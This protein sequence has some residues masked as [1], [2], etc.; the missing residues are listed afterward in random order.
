MDLLL[1]FCG[2]RLLIQVDGRS[3]QP[4]LEPGERVLVKPLRQGECPLAG[5]VVLAWHPERNDLRIIKRLHSSEA[6]AYWVLG[7]NPD[8]ST[9]SRQFGPI[10]SSRLIG[11]V[12]GRLATNA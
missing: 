1:L 8:A 10:D 6:T 2:R 9:D 12:T 5:Q 4:T 3:M 7:D 11:I